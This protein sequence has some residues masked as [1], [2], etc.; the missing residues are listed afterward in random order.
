MGVF[1][2]ECEGGREGPGVKGVCAP[3]SMVVDIGL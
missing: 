2:E 3:G 1:P